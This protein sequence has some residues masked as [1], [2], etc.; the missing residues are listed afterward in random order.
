MTAFCGFWVMAL[1]APSLVRHSVTSSPVDTSCRP[2]T[3][4]HS[5]ASLVNELSAAEHHICTT[6][7]H[8]PGQYCGAMIVWC[9]AINLTMLHKVVPDV[10]ILP[11]TSTSQSRPR[12]PATCGMAKTPSAA[13]GRVASAREFQRHLCRKCNCT[14]VTMKVSAY[15]R[16]D[17]HVFL[18]CDGEHG[19]IVKIGDIPHSLAEM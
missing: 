8:F 13:G 6:Q 11:D 2:I 9:G 4:Q 12:M 3:P 17:S 5:R 19:V 15:Q 14:V 10:L 16:N 1:Q 18:L 7:S